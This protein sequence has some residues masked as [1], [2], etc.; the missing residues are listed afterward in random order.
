MSDVIS[1]HGTWPIS[2]IGIRGDLQNILTRIIHAAACSGLA[3]DSRDYLA[4]T[5]LGAGPCPQALQNLA[6]GSES[7]TSGSCRAA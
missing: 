4:Q 7:L 3:S 5:R 6:R 1:F 2:F